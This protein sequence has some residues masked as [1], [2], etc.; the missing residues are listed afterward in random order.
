MDDKQIITYINSQNANTRV[1]CHTNM[2]T[3]L[4][5]GIHKQAHTN[6]YKNRLHIGLEKCIMCHKPM[7]NDVGK[8]RCGNV[9]LSMSKWS[10]VY[11]SVFRYHVTVRSCRPYSLVP[12]SETIPRPSALFCL[13]K[14]FRSKTLTT[15]N[16]QSI[17]KHLLPISPSQTR[18][19]VGS[20]NRNNQ[21]QERLTTKMWLMN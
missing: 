1:S 6:A 18:F 7:Q 19:R 14:A 15:S 20:Y 4:Q 12:S 13:S 21:K 3:Y 2:K 11:G 5:P 10:C 8:Q 17:Y 16:T 9:C